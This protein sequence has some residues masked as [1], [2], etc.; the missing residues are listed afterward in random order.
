MIGILTGRIE[1]TCG[2]DL[3]VFR[4]QLNALAWQDIREGRSRRRGHSHGAKALLREPRRQRGRRGLRRQV[5]V[6]GR[7]VHDFHHNARATG[8]GRI[9]AT[10]FTPETIGRDLDDSR[11]AIDDPSTIEAHRTAEYAGRITA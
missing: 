6:R 7:R 8:P 3:S 4:Q 2:E 1:A 10:F 11:D 5:S 9:V